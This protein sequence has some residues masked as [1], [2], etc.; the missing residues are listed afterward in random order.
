MNNEKWKMN[1]ERVGIVE[2]MQ[3]QPETVEYMLVDGGFSAS[4]RRQTPAIQRRRGRAVR[5]PG[6]RRP[7]GWG[8]SC[9]RP[10]L[11]ADMASARKMKNG[12]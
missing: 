6:M 9:L 12:T 5:A 7:R 4:A 11:E 2:L 8:T 1:N 10:S 3:A